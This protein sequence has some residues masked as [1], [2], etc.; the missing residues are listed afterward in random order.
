RERS[1]E[2]EAGCRESKSLRR[3]AST[4]GASNEMQSL[5]H[6][7]HRGRAEHR[8]ET[9]RGERLSC[10]GSCEDRVRSVTHGAIGIRLQHAGHG[11]RNGWDIELTKGEDGAEAY[12]PI[13][14][15]HQSLEESDRSAVLEPTQ[16]PD[17][18]L[19]RPRGVVEIKV[20][21]GFGRRQQRVEGCWDPLVK[22]AIELVSQGLKQG[23]REVHVI[24]DAAANQLAEKIKIGILL[25]F[26][27]DFH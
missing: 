24:L 25:E 5:Q 17:S 21:K 10:G 20:G 27:H 18:V 1:S 2:T 8:F 6:H 11:R 22:L 9:S 23:S 3:C 12:L 7:P 19:L 14:V 4:C 26:L 15:E 16:F 13:G